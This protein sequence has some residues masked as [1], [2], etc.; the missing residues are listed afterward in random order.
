MSKIAVLYKSKYGNTK[1]YAEWI[2]EDL[3]ADIFDISKKVSAKILQEYDI[4]IF[5]GGFI[6]AKVEGY[7]FFNS[8]YNQISDKKIIIFTVGITSVENPVVFAPALE[9]MYSKE[10]F[11]KI[12]FFHFRGKNE[13]E[14]LTF[15]DKL[16][17]KSIRSYLLTKANRDEGDERLLD[18]IDGVVDNTSRDYINDL[19]AYVNELN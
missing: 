18:A 16:R 19:V 6:S 10:V 14:R 9:K 8:I 17:I 4:I 13:M 7:K 11:D 12:K 2:C 1:Q 15:L 3:S 5:G